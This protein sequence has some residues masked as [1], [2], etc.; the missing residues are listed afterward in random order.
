LQFFQHSFSVNFGSNIRE[1]LN[2][3]DDCFQ[4]RLQEIVNAIQFL[5]NHGINVVGVELGNEMW[6][7]HK[8]ETYPN[9]VTPEKYFNLSG[10]ISERLKYEFSNI[11]VGIIIHY[12][13]CFGAVRK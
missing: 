13:A 3:N 12:D 6:S 2:P 7:E 5:I 9:H 11:P 10:I 1:C 8:A 4:N